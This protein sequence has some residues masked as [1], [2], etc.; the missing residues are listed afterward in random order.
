IWGPFMP[1]SLSSSNLKI[2][3]VQCGTQSRDI[4]IRK[5]SSD[6]FV[7]GQIFSDQSYNLSTVK[8]IGEITQLYY[9]ILRSGRDPCIVDAGAN[10][11]ASSVHFALMMK[12]A[13]V[14]S[15]EPDEQNFT[16]LKKNVDG[17]NVTAVRAALTSD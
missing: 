3:T 16:L 13:R 14:I 4:I 17:L 15:I 12:G 8:R 2:V 11:G 1:T 9:Y 5:A 6:R 7:L 10:I